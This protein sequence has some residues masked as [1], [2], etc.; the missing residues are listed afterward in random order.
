[1]EDVQVQDP[2]VVAAEAASSPVEAPQE[3]KH[4]LLDLLRN[5]LSQHPS[6]KHKV[7]EWPV[8]LW[9]RWSRVPLSVLAPRWLIRVSAP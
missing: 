7:V 2:E 8:D 9:A 5:Q 6:S 3:L 4:P 1:M